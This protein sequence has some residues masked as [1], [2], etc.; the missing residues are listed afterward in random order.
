[1]PS[2]LVDQLNGEKNLKKAAYVEIEKA[3]YSRLL[4][5]HAKNMPLSGAVLQEKACNR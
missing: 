1:M 4:D 3:L 5:M 2:V